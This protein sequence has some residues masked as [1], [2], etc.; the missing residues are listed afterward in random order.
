MTR[1]K[2]DYIIAVAQLGSFSK[3]AE[4]CFISQ[5]TLSAMISKFEQQCEL[6]IFNRKTKPISLTT[7]GVKVLEHLK[8]IRREYLLLDQSIKDLKGHSVRELSMAC[9]PTVAPYLYPQIL[10]KLSS[11]ISHVEIS[12]YELT[13]ERIIEEILSGQIDIGIVSTPLSNK[14]LDEYPLY[15]EDF[16]VYDFQE[17][18]K[19]GKYQISD[20]D[21]DRLWLLEEGHCLR[22][23]IIKIC[24]LRKQQKV[25]N[26][27]TYNCG[28]IYSLVEMVK[29]YKGVTL[30][31]RLAY[32][33]SNNIA[34]KNIHNL[35]DPVPTREIGIIT[36]AHFVKNQLLHKVID[37]ITQAV[38]P[39]LP[40]YGDDQTIIKPF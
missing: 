19:N 32:I 34:E 3:A 8:N 28:S 18:S 9:I 26:N 1:S 39:H 16:L 13:T 36:H 20:I 4:Y 7:D 35:L 30:I 14:E 17:G 15:R 22:N 24:E 6:V 23:Q 5:S 33:Y 10:G 29:L 27:I 37:T 12:I 2:I 25:S 38:H 31:P 40:I 21:M 11:L